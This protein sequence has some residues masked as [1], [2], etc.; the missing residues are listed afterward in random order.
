M[1]REYSCISACMPEGTGT[2]P[3]KHS[4]RLF[5]PIIANEIQWIQGKRFFLP[6]ICC[7]CSI[8]VVPLPTMLTWNIYRNVFLNLTPLSSHRVVLW[9][10][11]WG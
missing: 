4:S 2:S 5:H 3:S 6:I 8:S 7:Y 11:G 9:G 10:W 1:E